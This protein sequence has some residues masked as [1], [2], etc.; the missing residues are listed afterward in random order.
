MQ[1]EPDGEPETMWLP[2]CEKAMQYATDGGGITS[3]DIALSLDGGTTATG[4]GAKGVLGCLLG[5]IEGEPS[6]RSCSNLGE[7]FMVGVYSQ[8]VS[9]KLR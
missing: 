6:V 8:V 4:S 2:C 9:T 1:I 7:P 5:D 3:V